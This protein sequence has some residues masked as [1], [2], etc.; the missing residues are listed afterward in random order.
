VIPT[1]LTAGVE[2]VQRLPDFLV[3]DRNEGRTRWHR[4]FDTP[5]K[6]QESMKNYYRLGTE[7]DTACGS[8]VDELERQGVLSNT[9]VIFTTDNGYLHGEHGLAD[10]WY[11]FEESIRVP[12]IVLDPRLSPNHRGTTDDAIV[13]NVDLAPTIL[14]AAGLAAPPRMQGR[15]LAPLYLD[16]GVAGADQVVR[17]WRTDFFYEHPTIA[18]IERIP[19]SE[20]LV[21]KDIK[22]VTWP[23]YDL[24]QL[25]DLGHDP[26]ETTDVICDPAYAAHLAKAR[27]R[28]DEG[29]ATAQ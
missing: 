12:L 23:D 8:V 17:Q 10:K 29:K 4:R 6:Y 20:A 19:Y 3:S 26:H 21:R 11:P 7:V 1:P 28:F 22:Y 14:R 15:D 5:E 18:R 9:L 16:K 25:F 24:E 13:L 2:H 27:A